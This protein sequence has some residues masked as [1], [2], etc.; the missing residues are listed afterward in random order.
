M[1]GL[2]FYLR[3]WSLLDS[4]GFYCGGGYS[5]HSTSLFRFVGTT[6]RLK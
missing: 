2:P 4:G 3:V 1:R 5:A 6:L